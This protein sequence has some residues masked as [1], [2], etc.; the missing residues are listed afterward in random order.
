MEA[1]DKC[2][3]DVKDLTFC[4]HCEAKFCGVCLPCHKLLIIRNV[5]TEGSHFVCFLMIV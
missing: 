5:T 3:H 2:T 1:K 4:Q